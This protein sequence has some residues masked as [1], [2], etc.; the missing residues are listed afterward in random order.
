MSLTEDQKR[1]L[2]GFVEDLYDDAA[3]VP[4]YEVICNAADMQSVVI[5]LADALLENE[6]L[7]A[8]LRDYDAAFLA[9]CA[10]DPS[11]DEVD[12]MLF[13]N[14]WLAHERARERIE[15]LEGT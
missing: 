9:W 11:D 12:G 7:R 4:H 15:E 13:E 1:V 8:T 3:S 5:Q 6:R 10:S 14:L 2:P